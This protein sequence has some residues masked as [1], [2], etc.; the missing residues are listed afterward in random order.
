VN[1]KRRKEQANA[2]G[3][4]DRMWTTQTPIAILKEVKAEYAKLQ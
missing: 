2:A 3:N 4:G 1:V